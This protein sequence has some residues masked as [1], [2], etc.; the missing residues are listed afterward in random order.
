MAQF[1]LLWIERRNYS[2]F[3][4][5]EALRFPPDYDDWLQDYSRLVMELHEQRH[6]ILPVEFDGREFEAY[7]ARNGLPPDPDSLARYVRFRASACMD[8]P[9]PLVA[10]RSG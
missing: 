6:A 7:C 2:G 4:R 5:I 9:P 1:P 3:R 10:A 8:F